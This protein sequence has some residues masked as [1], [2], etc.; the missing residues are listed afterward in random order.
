MLLLIAGTCLVAF[1]LLLYMLSPLISPKPLALPGAHV[2]VTGGSSGI[3][4]CI[5]IECYKQGAFITLVA[6]NEERLLQAKKEIE[7]HSINDKQVVLCISVDVS[8]DY[9]QVENVIKQA[10]EKL[11]PVDMLIN[12]AGMSVSGKFED[13]EVSTFEKL[14]S[15]N[16]LGSVYP[17]RAVITTMKERRVGRIVFLSSQAGQVGLFGY[18]A[19]SPS[20]FAIKGLAEALQMEPLET[21]LIS[22]TTSI[23]T[24]E[25]VAKQ[26]VK[27]AI[28]GNFNSSIG[29]DGYMLSSLTCGMSPVTSITEG[30]Q[31]VVTM[32]LFRMISL[33][34]LGSFDNII[35]RCMIERTK[36][37]TA[38]KTA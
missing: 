8:Q 2:V 3:G 21:R 10:Q 34:Y 29:S 14:M 16:Y 22:E 18:T 30:L 23:C 26:I 36:Y 32:G 37:G 15:I 4:K 5:A 38:D 11:G 28:Q 9:S 35:R 20:K 12:C 13:V 33:F 24:P 6:R 7:K 31:Q 19:Y 25:Q 27:D 17:S 1:V